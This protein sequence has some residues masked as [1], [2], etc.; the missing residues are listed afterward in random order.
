L[1]ALRRDPNVSKACI[2]S[3]LSAGWSVEEAIELPLASAVNQRFADSV[4]TVDGIAKTVGEWAAATG[5]DVALIRKRK[6]KGWPLDRAVSTGFRG[7][8]LHTLDGET[9]TL[10]E[11]SKIAGIC[12]DKLKNRI[13]K[14]QALQDALK[15]TTYNKPIIIDGIEGTINEWAEKK[16][17]PRGII[18]SR[19]RRG[20]TPEEA[21]TKPYEPKAKKVTAVHDGIEK[22]HTFK[23]W[24]AILGVHPDQIYKRIYQGMPVEKAVTKPFCGQKGRNIVITAKWEGEEHALSLKEWSEITGILVET[25]KFRKHDLNWSW[26]K[27]VSTPARGKR[28]QK[29]KVNKKNN[30]KTRTLAPPKTTYC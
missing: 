24:G 7:S 23:E 11:W 28:K 13:S 20:A 18:D 26:E 2:C 14:G 21:I 8:K 30:D 17:I 27:A 29:N 9:H 22:T 16:G 10:S 3:R 12:Y 19:I 25:M 5:I 4:V 6:G 1:Y 15:E